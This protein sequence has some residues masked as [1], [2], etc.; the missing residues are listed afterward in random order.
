MKSENVLGASAQLL[1]VALLIV[2]A[3]HI[4]NHAAHSIADEVA[5]AAAILF[6][7]CC[8]TGH[9]AI[10]RN[11]D[12]LDEIADRIFFVGLLTLLFAALTFW[13]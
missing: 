8:L 3:V 7:A 11:N 4:T 1:G 13:F 5:F 12:R 9:M 10:R 2:T 6:I